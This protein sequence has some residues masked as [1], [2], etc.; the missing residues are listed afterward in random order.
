MC[1][2]DRSQGSGK[3]GLQQA[4]DLLERPIGPPRDHIGASDAVQTHA[5]DPVSDAERA[6]A[7]R[8]MLKDRHRQ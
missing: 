4:R 6:A 7:C 8:D 2:R 5:V 3:P 1:I